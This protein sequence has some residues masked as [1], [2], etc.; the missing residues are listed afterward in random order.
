M[1]T[2]AEIKT[3][4]GNA[5][6]ADENVRKKYGIANGATFDKVF[7]VVSIENILFYC[8]AF[9]IWL[10]ENILD[11]HKQEVR[12]DLDA[13]LPHTA[14]WYRNQVLSFEHDGD[15]PIKYC[16]VNEFDNKLQIKI[17]SGVAGSR[18]VVNA[19]AASALASWLQQY[20]DA[21]TKIV[22]VNENRD[23]IMVSVDVY[24]DALYLRPAD[25]KV[26]NAIREYV[27]N[28]DF[29]GIL[30]Y[31]NLNNAILAVEGVKLANI[32]SCMVQY[33][34][35]TPVALGVQRLSTS[36]YWQVSSVAVNYQPY[37]AVN[38]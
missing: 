8:C 10:L 4:I 38:I 13:R 2:I 28:L 18:D 27:S 22:I 21:G 16:A 30:T 1:R 14:L 19:D 7:S 33:A 24:Y 3:E 36:G 31:N 5:Y 32:T 37:K 9:G 23:K 20:K 29:D 25:G 34:E 11:S 17:A 15:K 26:E 6:I 12:A 35:D